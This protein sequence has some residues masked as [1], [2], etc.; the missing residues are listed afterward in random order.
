MPKKLEVAVAW[1]GGTLKKIRVGTMMLPPAMPALPEAIPAP[2]PNRLLPAMP[3]NLLSGFGCQL[4]IMT[5]AT[6]A[7]NEA[8][9]IFRI[10]GLRDETRIPESM[11]PTSRDGS[12]F[13]AIS[14]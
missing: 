8:M 5:K 10:E 6:A 9:M 11:L 2:A 4:E 14:H 3:G 1:C 7:K 13:R 12:N